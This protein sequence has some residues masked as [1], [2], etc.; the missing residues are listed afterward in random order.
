MIITRENY[1]L[2]H[3]FTILI[4]ASV[5]DNYNRGNLHNF[6]PLRTR[7]ESNEHLNHAI[8]IATKLWPI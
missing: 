6:Y 8:F 7:K 4:L 3:D 1:G 2:S 5:I